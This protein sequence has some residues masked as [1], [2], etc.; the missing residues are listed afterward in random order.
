MYTLISHLDSMHCMR[1]IQTYGLYGQARA[2]EM[3]RPYCCIQRIVN[4]VYGAMIQLAGSIPETSESNH[5]SYISSLSFLVAKIDIYLSKYM[6]AFLAGTTSEL[7]T[8]TLRSQ[9]A[10]SEE[11]KKRKRDALGQ[12]HQPTQTKP[13]SSMS[14]ASSPSQNHTA[15][16]NPSTTNAP[17]F[18]HSTTS[19]TPGYSQPALEPMIPS[20]PISITVPSIQSTWHRLIFWILRNLFYTRPC[21]LTIPSEQILGIILQNRQLLIY[22]QVPFLLRRTRCILLMISR[23]IRKETCK[24]HILRRNGLI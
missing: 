19:T 23:N 6:R 7:L 14:K 15:L 12:A 10:H 17:S 5:V 13:S 9:A 22:T 11:S 2:R 1:D 3:Y 24:N 21:V 18:L 20:T 8:E 4:A 16:E